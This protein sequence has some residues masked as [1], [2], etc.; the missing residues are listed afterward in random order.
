MGSS[1]C[2]KV[3]QKPRL[4]KR[5]QQVA[6]VCY[7]IRKHRIEFLLVQTR[8][9]R[10]I[11][12]K[13]G[14]GP[15]FTHAQSA[16][17]EAFE[18]AGVHGRMEEVPFARYYRRKPDPADTTTASPAELAVAAHLCAVTRLET[19]QESD[20][21][22]TWFAIEKAKQRLREE[23][24]LEFGA[25]LARVVDRAEARIGRL[26]GGSAVASGNANLSQGKLL[27]ATKDGLQE[28]RFEALEVARERGLVQAGSY[29]RYVRRGYAGVNFSSD[30]SARLAISGGAP[31]QL[32]NGSASSHERV[33]NVRSIDEGRVASGTMKSTKNRKE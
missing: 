19:P 31:A 21:N 26:H 13:G 14:V 30:R 4:P 18:E 6:A 8:E 25:E 29:G 16:A 2:V 23:R 28:V 20:R 1:A 22:P 24:T 27:R 33:H 11:F 10:W 15:G 12:P 32:T 5:R 9:G 17:V 3:L 7:R